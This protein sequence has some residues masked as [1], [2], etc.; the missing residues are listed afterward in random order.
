MKKRTLVWLSAL[1]SPLGTLGCQG[2]G[3]NEPVPRP[4]AVEARLEQ[5]ESAARAESALPPDPLVEPAT[6]GPTVNVWPAHGARFIRGARF[7]IRV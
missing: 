3:D 2:Q 6:G 5:T 4:A 7:D 1:A